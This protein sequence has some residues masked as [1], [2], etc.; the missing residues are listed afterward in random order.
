MNIIIILLSTFVYAATPITHPE[1][2][3]QSVATVKLGEPFHFCIYTNDTAGKITMTQASVHNLNELSLF[4]LSDG[5]VGKVDGI[6]SSWIGMNIN[7]NHVIHPDAACENRGKP[8]SQ[9]KQTACNDVHACEWKDDKCS[10][11]NGSSSGYFASC[12]QIVSSGTKRVSISGVYVQVN[13]GKVTK[14]SV[15]NRCNDCGDTDCV[16]SENQDTEY[17]GACRAPGKGYSISIT[18]SGTD[19]EGKSLLSSSKRLSAFGSSSKS[20][21]D[22]LKE[23]I[24]AIKSAVST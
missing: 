9:I 11:R 22:T 1:C 5:T 16:A 19:S 15:D 8:C 6:T 24:N 23:K 7:G 13:E 20:M 12:E 4:K 18:F 2:T 10:H 17:Y 3:A 14:V 21:I